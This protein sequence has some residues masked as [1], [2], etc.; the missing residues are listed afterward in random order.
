MANLKQEL[1]IQR[2]RQLL[3]D[4]DDVSLLQLIA[5]DAGARIA[6]ITHAATVE[7]HPPLT[8]EEILQFVV[9][10]P[11]LKFIQQHCAGRAAPR[12]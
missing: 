4:V 10:P 9:Q 12:S 11:S 2:A 6:A 5:D 8:R 3:Q 7:S 1:D